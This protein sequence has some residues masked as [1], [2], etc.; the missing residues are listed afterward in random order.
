MRMAKLVMTGLVSV[1]LAS[2][3]YAAD[4]SKNSDDELIK[5]N[6]GKL[7]AADA[8]DLKL[9]VIKRANKLEGEAKKAF[10]DKVKAAY[11]KATENFKVKDFRAYEES[12]RKE[13]KAKIDALSE[14]AKQEFGIT[15]GG[16][17]HHG[18]GEHKQDEK[19]S[20]HKH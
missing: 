1:S 19:S 7:K 12:V 17:P 3:G 9:E 4:Y 10:L 14:E 20:E 15:G 11:D 13:F 5:L 18:G 6:N 2:V 8:A 16:C